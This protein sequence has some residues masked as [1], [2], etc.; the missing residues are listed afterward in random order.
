MRQSGSWMTIWDD[1]ILE[2]VRE[3]GNGSPTELANR[4]EIHISKSS[5]SRRLTKLADNGLLRPL[6]NGVYVLSEAGEAYLEGK[7]DAEQGR[8]IGDDDETKTEG[9]ATER[10]GV[11]G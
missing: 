2:V 9:D 8:Y 1:R 7:Y 6:A 4:E 11:D 10:P 5:V 3:E